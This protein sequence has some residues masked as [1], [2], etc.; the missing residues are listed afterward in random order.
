MSDRTRGLFEKFIVRRTDGTSEVGKKHDGCEYF[1]LDMTHDPYAKA[2]AQAYVE[3]CRADY[4]LLAAD[5]VRDFKLRAE[6]LAPSP[7]TGQTTA[8]SLLRRLRSALMDL[9]IDGVNVWENWMDDD[10]VL[11]REVDAVLNGVAVPSAE[12]RS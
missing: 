6:A 10:G 2:A 9:N 7:D 3:A 8:L 12:K 4:P 5:M 11:H 1:V